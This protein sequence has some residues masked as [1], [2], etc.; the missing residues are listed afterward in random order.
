MQFLTSHSNCATRLGI[1]PGS[2]NPPT[3]AHLALAEGALSCREAALDEV[4][5]VLPRAFPHKSYD[6]AGFTQ[7]AQM[8]HA[9]LGGRTRLAAA[10]TD[11]G[12]FVEIAR[13]CRAAYRGHV[14]L[15]FICGRDAA[16]RM[17]GWNYGN[18][19]FISEILG[20]FGLL[21]AS[22]DGHY[23]PP[24][25]LT[26]HIRALPLAA[27]LSQVSASDVRRRIRDGI[28]WE[29]LVPAAVVPLARE[30]YRPA[31]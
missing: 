30:I 14:Q 29:H 10:A 2:F 3:L 17:V 18:P 5:L 20:S 28:A 13:E 25:H 26:R 8:L 21:V 1:L 19:N 12:L 6:G 23:E 4:L 24:P 31:E 16:E 27:D 11:G 9:M 22:R 7:R 15:D